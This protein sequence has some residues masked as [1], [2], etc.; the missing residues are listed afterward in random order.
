MSS[1]VVP[2]PYSFLSITFSENPAP[3]NAAHHNNKYKFLYIKEGRH[4]TYRHCPVPNPQPCRHGPPNLLSP[5]PRI[6]YLAASDSCLFEPVN[7]TRH[8][9]SCRV[10][11]PTSSSR[12]S[13]GRKGRRASVVDLYPRDGR[14]HGEQGCTSVAINYT[15]IVMYC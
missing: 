2:A 11:E 4:Q 5:S 13:E 12:G 14:V 6:P 1:C 3:K 10:R 9:K 15:R 7:A 8:P